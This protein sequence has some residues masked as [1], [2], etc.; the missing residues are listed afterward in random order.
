MDINQLTQAAE[1]RL[2]KDRETKVAS[3]VAAGKA[4]QHSPKRATP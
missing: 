4:E 2:T 1:D 3:V